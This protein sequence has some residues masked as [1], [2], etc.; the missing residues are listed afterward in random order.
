MFKATK[1]ERKLREIN[2]RID[3]QINLSSCRTQDRYYFSPSF[4]RLSWDLLRTKNVSSTLAQNFWKV[5]K[6]WLAK[7]ARE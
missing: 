4:K 5:N 6:S 3:M 2:V 1:V 7:N